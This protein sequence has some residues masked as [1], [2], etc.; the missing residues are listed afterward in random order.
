[1]SSPT[2]KAFHLR[3]PATVVLTRELIQ[4]A[5]MWVFGHARFHSIWLSS[6][7]AYVWVQTEGGLVCATKELGDGKHCPAGPL[8]PTEA[9]NQLPLTTSQRFDIL[10]LLNV[11]YYVIRK[12][13]FD[14]LFETRPTTAPGNT[15]LWCNAVA[16]VYRRY[17]SAHVPIE[18]LCTLYFSE[19]E[20]ATYSF[21]HKTLRQSLLFLNFL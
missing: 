10:L 2:A 6:D 5:R 21:W 1:L 12:G 8:Q 4:S 13:H 3:Y 18:R 19:D 20:Y 15:C 11:R 17:L 14:P 9:H 7:L 16:W